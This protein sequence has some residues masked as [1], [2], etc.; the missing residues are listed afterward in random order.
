MG[1]YSSLA[2][3]GVAGSSLYGSLASS[4]SSSLGSSGLAGSDSIT[5]YNTSWSRGT[6]GG[7]VPTYPSSVTLT[8]TVSLSGAS[9]RLPDGGPNGEMKPL[10]RQMFKIVVD[11]DP[12]TTLGEALATADR[13]TWKGLNLVVIGTAVP[14]QGQFQIL[15][16]LV[17]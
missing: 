7:P 4:A 11:E 1:I 17:A 8:G 6:R 12:A 14:D 13:A 2:G 5:F 16:E 3:G 9:T 10:A 15:A